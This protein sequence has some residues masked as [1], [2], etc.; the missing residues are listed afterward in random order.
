MKRNIIPFYVLPGIAVLCCL[1]IGSIAERSE[2]KGLEKG[3]ATDC[4]V[5]GVNC[6]VSCSNPEMPCTF[7]VVLKDGMSDKNLTYKW[8][9]SKG[10]ISAGEGTPTITVDLSGTNRK[11]VTAV[12]EIGGLAEECNKSFS[13]STAVH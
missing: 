2:G 6:S 3:V 11:G 13:C 9:V 1:C 5:A 4:P 10:K 12:V 8:E 7:N